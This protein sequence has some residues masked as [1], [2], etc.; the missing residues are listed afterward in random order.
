VNEKSTIFAVP[1]EGERTE[2]LRGE[3][4]G[5]MFIERMKKDVANTQGFF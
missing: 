3:G 1:N 4:R 2:V 5:G